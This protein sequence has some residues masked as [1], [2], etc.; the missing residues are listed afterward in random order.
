MYPVA[1]RAI[2]PIL[3]IALFVILYE[4]LKENEPAILQN[5]QQSLE[6]E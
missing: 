6:I 1:L 2:S 5:M 4:S 3:P